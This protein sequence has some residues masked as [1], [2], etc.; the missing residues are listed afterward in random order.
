MIHALCTLLLLALAPPNQKGKGGDPFASHLFPPE[1]VIRHQRA[2]E[3]TAEQRATITQAIAETQ[4]NVLEFEWD[5]A[6]ESQKLVELLK[7]NQVDEDAA[8]AQAEK[9]MALE[10][11][12]KKAHL[13]LVIRIKNTLTPSQQTKLQALRGQA[14]Q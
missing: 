9:L 2:I 5:V 13:S 7:Q 10:R 3:L 12:V 6:S 11:N 8:L 14:K 4:A 1:L